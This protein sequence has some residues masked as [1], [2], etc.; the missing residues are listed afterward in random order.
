MV[1]AD[2]Y[3]F[4]PD[5]DMV[6][7]LRIFKSFLHRGCYKLDE[8]VIRGVG[9]Y[10][11]AAEKVAAS[12]ATPGANGLTS[13]SLGVFINENSDA[14]G[15]GNYIYEFIELFKDNQSTRLTSRARLAGVSRAFLWMSTRVSFDAL[16]VRTHRFTEVARVGNSY[17]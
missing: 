11:Y 8:I 17:N 10:A 14:L 2:K 13:C 16:F 12:S 1:V 7:F 6:F 5:L 15:N 9:D 4:G 3:E